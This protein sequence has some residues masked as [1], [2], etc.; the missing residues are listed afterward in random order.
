MATLALVWAR[1]VEVRAPPSIGRQVVERLPDAP[2]T[3]RPGEGHLGGFDA[4][5]EVLG[6]LLDLWDR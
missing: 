2:L 3:V 1:R 6:T 5:V 4:A